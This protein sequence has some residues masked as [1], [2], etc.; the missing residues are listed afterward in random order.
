MAVECKK[1]GKNFRGEED[2]GVAVKGEGTTLQQVVTAVSS[3]LTHALSTPERRCLYS[4]KLSSS[5]T[6]PV[7]GFFIFG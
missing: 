1:K 6:S 3:R 5:S 4:L 2:E 7:L